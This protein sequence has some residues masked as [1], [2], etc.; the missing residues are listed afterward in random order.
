MLVSGIPASRG[1]LLSALRHPSLVL[2]VLYILASPFYVFESGLPQPGDMLIVLLVPISLYRWDGR[3]WPDASH[4]VRALFRFVA[5]TLLTNACWAIATGHTGIL[6]PDNFLLFPV[7]YVYNALVVI[8]ALVL[9]RRYGPL[10]LRITGYAVVATVAM[11]CATAMFYGRGLSRGTLF[12]ENPNQL[13]YFA[14]LAACMLLLTYWR[15]SIRAI[16]SMAAILGCGYLALYSA[17]RAAVAGIALLLVLVAFAG[18]RA[19]ILASLGVIL[20]VALGSPL[21]DAISAAQNRGR[22]A[23]FFEERRYDRILTHIEYV[24]LGAGEGGLWR[25][26]TDENPHPIEIHSAPATILFSYGLI[27]FGLFSAFLWRL[28]RGAPVRLALGLVP[29]LAY[30]VAHQGLRF[31]ML[32]VL[33]AVF[34]SLKADTQRRIWTVPR[35]VLTRRSRA[36]T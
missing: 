15:S 20:A 33:L 10:F 26:A 35:A 22:D 24:P 19:L 4:I 17:S 28:L 2:W 29:A 14:L 18:A 34:I 23:E 8:A 16:P 12:F 25:F 31:T 7:Y 9:Y 32:W 1:K 5:W 13:G 27:G 11:L 6:G 21:F 3:L 30:T 36:F